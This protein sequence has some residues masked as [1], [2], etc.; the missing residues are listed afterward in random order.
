MM[1]PSINPPD[2]KETTSLEE[3]KI[4][5][6]SRKLKLVKVIFSVLIE[7]PEKKSQHQEEQIYLT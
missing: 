5:P 3:L 7:D 6:K 2:Q 1:A 4:L